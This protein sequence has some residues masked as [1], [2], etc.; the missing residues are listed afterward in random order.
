MQLTL[1]INLR[2]PLFIILVVL[3]VVVLLI[4]YRLDS[5]FEVIKTPIIELS[6]KQIPIPP[7]PWIIAGAA[8]G[9]QKLATGPA[10]V[11]S[12]LLFNLKNQHVEAFVLI[13]T[14]AA[15]AVNGWG[16]SKDCKNSK[17]Y[18]GA[19]YEQQNHN[20]KCAFVGKLDQKQ[21][22][23]AWPFATALAAEQHWQFPDKW[24]V[25]GIRLADRLDVLDV[26]YGFSTEFFKDNQEHTIPKDEDIHIKVVLQALVNW[27][28]TALYLVDRGFRKQLDNELP[29]P[30]PTLDPHSLPLS[31]VVL[32]R[33]QQLHS[34]RDNGWLTAAEFAEQSELL[35][36]SIQTQSDLTVDIWRLGAIKTAGHTVQSTVWMWGVNY[37]FLGNAYL[38]GSLALTKGFIS[39]IRYYLEE[40]AWNLWGPRRNPKLPM[41]DFSN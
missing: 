40:T 4:T 12:K 36:N 16:I 37:L 35:K 21:V 15:P 10:M 34:L 32:S 28:N 25:V 30:L 23:L 17:Y 6:N 1:P 2:K 18:F 8:H 5:Q 26:R 7:R 3:L 24:L 9:E 33:M 19:V 22:A 20:Y 13:H 39:P 41:I 14:N 29:L 38:S 11:E 27:Q 31:T